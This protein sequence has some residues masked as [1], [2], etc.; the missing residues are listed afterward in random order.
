MSSS[1]RISDE[2]EADVNSSLRVEPRTIHDSIAPLRDVFEPDHGR[3]DPMF[4]VY[5][6]EGDARGGDS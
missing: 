3:L 5:G 4:N 6:V 2:G 1:E